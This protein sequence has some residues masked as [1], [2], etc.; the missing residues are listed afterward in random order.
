MGRFYKGLPDCQLRI[1]GMYPQCLP[2]L[3]LWFSFCELEFNIKNT[4]RINAFISFFALGD[5]EHAAQVI[6]RITNSPR[7]HPSTGEGDPPPVGGDVEGSNDK[8]AY[9]IMGYKLSWG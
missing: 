1:S 5:V 7:P 4:R 2:I 9:L 8:F 3:D 6:N